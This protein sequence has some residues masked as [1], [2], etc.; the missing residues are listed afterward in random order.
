MAFGE[1]TSIEVEGNTPLPPNPN[2]VYSPYEYKNPTK[3]IQVGS[4]E[5]V[6]FE[7]NAVYTNDGDVTVKVDRNALTLNTHYT[8]HKGSTHVILKGSYVSTLLLVHIL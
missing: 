7:T 6:E 4:T 3:N 1:L 8:Q 5:D 2:G